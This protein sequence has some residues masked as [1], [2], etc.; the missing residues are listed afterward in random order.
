MKQNIQAPSENERRFYR[1]IPNDD[2]TVDVWLTPG[3]PVPMFDNQTRQ[4]DYNLRIMAVRGVEPWPG[5]ETDIRRRYQSW[6]DSAEVI[7]I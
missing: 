2:G 5:L 7:E 4:Y 6:I 3:E 1:I